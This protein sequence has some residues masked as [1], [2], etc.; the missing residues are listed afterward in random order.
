[1]PPFG[2]G[3]H[4]P[5]ALMGRLFGGEVRDAVTLAVVVATCSVAA[6]GPVLNTALDH[7]RRC[8]RCRRRSSQPSVGQGES[9][10]GSN[11][12]PRFGPASLVIERNLIACMRKYPSG[13]SH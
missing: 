12:M 1:M 7:A 2:S 3:T 11:A 10:A 6:N 4:G 13:H 5:Q 9:T 8:G